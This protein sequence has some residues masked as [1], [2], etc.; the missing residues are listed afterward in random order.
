MRLIQNKI[1]DMYHVILLKK[2]NQLKC[3]IIGCLLTGKY[4]NFPGLYAMQIYPK[5]LKSSVK[6]TVSQD[7][8]HSVFFHQTITPWG[9]GSRAK[10]VTNW[11][12]IRRDIRVG[13]RG[14]FGDKNR[15]S[16]ISWHCPFKEKRKM[17]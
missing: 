10:A 15:G 16:K 1:R 5:M 13:S 11:L 2:S 14:V 6:G 4:F 3:V 7:F 9:L 8:R 12:R 17:F